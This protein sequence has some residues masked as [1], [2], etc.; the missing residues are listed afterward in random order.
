VVNSVNFDHCDPSIFTVLTSP[1]EVPG[2]ANVDFVIFPPRWSVAERTFRPPYYH[3]NMMSEFMGLL[4][5]V[6]DAKEEGFV[7]GGASL[8]NCMSAHGPD[9]QTFDKASAAEL[10]PLYMGDTLAFMFESSLTFTPTEFAVNGGLLQRDY[11][12]CWKDLQKH[13]HP[14]SK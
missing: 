10:K 3:R 9:K 7:P 14:D 4:L 6:Y 13:F 11:M 1:S 8:H 2:F 12:S 5:G